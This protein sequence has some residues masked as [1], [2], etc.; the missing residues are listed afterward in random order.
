M[1]IGTPKELKNR[2]YRVGLTPQGAQELVRSGHSVF[3]ETGAGEMVGFS[4]E[5][6]ESAGCTISTNADELFD[7]SDMIIKVK[8]PQPVEIARLQPRHTL[9]TYLH[10]A[11]DPEQTRGLLK[12]GATCI[13]YETVTD[14]FGRLPLL[15]PMS[16]VA[17]RLS[18]QAGAKYLEIAQGGSGTLLGGVT[19]V[20]PGKVL[21]IGGGVAGRNAAEMAVGLG[22]NVTILDRSLDRLRELDAFFAGRARCLYSTSAA[23]EAS[24]LTAD[25]VV[26]AVLLPGSAAPKVVSAEQISMMKPGSVVVD[27]AIDQGGCFETSRPT[28]HDEPVYN[29]D[30]VCHYCVTNMPAAVARTSTIALSNATLPYAM[31][32]ADL[33]TEQAVKTDPHLHAGINVAH[34]DIVHPEIV[35]AMAG[36]I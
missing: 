27:I 33:G 13:A 24:L 30:G 23:I 1:R 8:E 16:E 22:A 25:L 34:G 31:A 28:T 12:S 29:V 7:S 19:G 14:R 17:G 4:D 10:L 32:L 21:V 18:V 20:A 9:F 6:Y 11:P 2:E 26:G 5:L 35:A 15:T 36:L 3:V